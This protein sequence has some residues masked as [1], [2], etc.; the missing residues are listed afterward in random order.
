MKGIPFCDIIKVWIKEVINLIR[1]KRNER[2][3][4]KCTKWEKDKINEL[5]DNKGNTV[6]DFLR[7]LIQDY[8]DKNK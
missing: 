2:I 5:A 8:I 7:F 1:D 4:L 6:S 3:V